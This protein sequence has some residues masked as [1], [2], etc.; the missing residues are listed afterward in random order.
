MVLLLLSIHPQAAVL[1]MEAGGQRIKDAWLAVADAEAAQD[2]K[3]ASKE[4][5]VSRLPCLKYQMYAD[6][7]T[8][9]E[10]AQTGRSGKHGCIEWLKLCSSACSNVSTSPPF[11]IDYQKAYY[12]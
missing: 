3:L 9:T 11:Q 5:R 6:S 10:L 1:A 2:E 7:S 4:Q 8:S 12:F